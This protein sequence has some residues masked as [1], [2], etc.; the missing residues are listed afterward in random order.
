[1]P[2]M[3]LYGE[4]ARTTLARG[5]EK[6]TRAIEATLGPRG[7][8][9]VIDRPLGTPLVSRDGVSIADEI[10]LDDRFENMGAQIV[11]EVAKETNKV[12]GDGTTTAVVLA[13]ALIQE[14]IAALDRS[15]NTVALFEGMDLAVEAALR[16]LKKLA[17]PVTSDAQLQCVSVISAGDP[18]LGKF[19]A[20]AVRAAGQDGM[21]Q[22][23]PSVTGKTSLDILNGISIDRGYLSAH[24][25]NQVDRMEA[26]LDQPLILLTD[27]V[28]Q[29]AAQIEPV[30]QIA[31]QAKRPLLV[32]A[33]QVSSEALGYLLAPG[34]GALP[35]VAVHAPEFGH[36]RKAVLEDIATLTGGRY[37]SKD[38]GDKLEEITISDLGSAREARISLESTVITGGK[39][40]PAKIHGR[41]KQIQRQLETME[42]PIERD[43]LEE[44]FA[45]M[46]GMAA[47]IHVGG[48]TPAEQKRRLQMAEDALNAVRAAAE[49]GILAGGG[50]ALAHVANELESLALASPA[51]SQEGVRTV[52]RA[53]VQPLI[54]I[55][56]NCGFSPQKVIEL[57]AD[58][59]YGFGLNARTGCFGNLLEE[60]ILDP[61]KVTSTALTNALSVAKLVLGAQTLIADKPDFHDPT[62]GPA[63]GGGAERYG[64]DYALEEMSP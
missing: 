31:L 49:E 34:E 45:R 54:C 61:V 47:V 24:M 13:N 43:K 1:M 40:D 58:S 32:I 42:Q 44:R 63:R 27:H 3:L 21:V 22:I 18:V 38:L 53:L 64:L 12:A 16:Q 50:T 23:E 51:A 33:D 20:D 9:A 5:V 56:R 8:N 48:S 59:P 36:W 52:Q 15:A 25:A 11:R 4:E 2:K 62:S 17:S 37:L 60:D 28:L 10:E 26:V 41:R 14:G 19:I 35:I 29:H 7:G 30:R 39:G 55:A 57:T 46:A 6:L